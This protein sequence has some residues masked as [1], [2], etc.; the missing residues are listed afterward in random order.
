MTT[1]R[2]MHDLHD[3]VI[4][5]ILGEAAAEHGD[6]PFLVF[7]EPQVQ[8]TYA[9]VDQNSSA[10][11]A[12]F[13][14][15]GLKAGDRALVL[16]GNRPE[17]VFSWLGIPKL[18]ATVVPVNPDWKG[19]T[20]EY[21]LLDADP[22]IVVVG[23]DI[24]ERV[25]PVIEKMNEVEAVVVCGE[26]PADAPA[27]GVEVV[28]WEEIAG[29]D[30]ADL[31][32]ARV[33][34]DNVLA[35]LYSSGTTGRP[36]G[37]MMPHAQI[38]AFARQWIRACNFGG[39]G[40]EEVLY[41]PTPLYYMLASIIG[42]VPT[43]I[44]GGR[45]HIAPRFSAATYWQDIRECEATT[46]HSVFSVI[47]II[48]KQPPSP[49]DRDHNCR[50]VYISKTN[51]EFEERFG[52]RCVEIYGSTEMNIVSY[53]PWDAPRDLSCGKAAPNFELK[54]V[55]DDDRE[56]PTG[57]VGEIVTRPREPFLI[58]YGYYNKGEATAEAWRN[59]WFHCGD[60]GYLDE[61]GYLFYVDRKKDV[62]RRRGENISSYELERQVNGHPAVLE[63][64]AI[65]VPS[66]LE[67]DDVMV[68]V[69]VKAGESVTG[70]ELAA[71]LED[72]LPK[73]MMP[74]F[75]DFVDEMPRTTSTKIEKYK[76]REL[77]IRA[78]AWDREKAARAHA[79]G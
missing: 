46:A 17:F 68:Y 9:E 3:Q 39:D 8:F 14:E 41:S 21:I 18:G 78:S 67:E 42:F 50:T 30:P 75:F 29:A 51:K 6:R 49:A 65:P 55:D 73:F 69:A 52:V 32:E 45:M 26:L 19:E 63:S 27:C 40:A 61:D 72:K 31:P 70:P 56:L 43:M 15:K 2:N 57:E 37:I 16:L 35:I 22:R 66:E 44:V 77:G 28:P 7:K 71:F 25:A 33:R 60:R 34:H 62:I 4:T 11:A 79:A 24:Y 76:L 58:S 64:A 20:L 13:A 54:I 23:A 10:A 59:L 1:E 48:L 12:G 53:N 38:Y 36:K 47:P 74:R 5:K